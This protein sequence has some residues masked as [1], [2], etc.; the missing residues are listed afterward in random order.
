MP[1]SSNAL[2]VASDCAPST[3]LARARAVTPRGNA[4]V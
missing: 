3:T 4:G 2:A 1:A